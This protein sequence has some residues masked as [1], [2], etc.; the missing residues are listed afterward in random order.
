MRTFPNST[1]LE[2]TGRNALV[3]PNL[4]EQDCVVLDSTAVSCSGLEGTGRDGAELLR[5]ALLFTAL[6]STAVDL[7]RP[8]LCSIEMNLAGRE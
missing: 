8:G 6:D 5:I 1:S 7:Y 3:V 2:W 4:I